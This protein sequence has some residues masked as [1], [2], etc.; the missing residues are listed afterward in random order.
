MLLVCVINKTIFSKRCLFL[1]LKKLKVQLL[2]DKN[3][4]NG[5]TKCLHII[6]IN[7]FNFYNYGIYIVS[8]IKRL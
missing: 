2:L 1:T 5:L 6:I 8:D 3:T 4:F 7:L